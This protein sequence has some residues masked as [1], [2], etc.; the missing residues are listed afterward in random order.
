MNEPETHGAAPGGG[1]RQWAMGRMFKAYRASVNAAS[2]AVATIGHYLTSVALPPRCCLCGAR[3]M[4]PQLDLCAACRA[5]L[6]ANDADE[7]AYPA[8]FTRVV[9][10]FRYSYPVDHLVRALKFKGE[11]M[12]ARV[13]GTLLANACTTTRS[14]VP[15]P[16]V[17]IP[18]PLHPS[19][20][21]ERGFNQSQELARYAS[22]SLHIPINTKCLT[23]VKPTQEQSALP[24]SDRIKNVRGAFALK[25]APPAPRIALIDDVL[26]TGSTAGEAARVLKDAGVVE[27]ELWAAARVVLD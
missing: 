19:R 24:L 18:I 21:R 11:R 25:C 7:D 8:V 15:L 13:L 2:G 5:D 6:P 16:L 9:V 20:Y 1:V 26:T 23:R 12:Y 14:S 10:P 27:V 17:L 3:G 22:H 4:A